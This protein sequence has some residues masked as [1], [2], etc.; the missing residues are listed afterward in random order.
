[1]TGCRKNHYEIANGLFQKFL[2]PLMIKET[3]FSYSYYAFLST[4]RAKDNPYIS[5]KLIFINITQRTCMPLYKDKQTQ[6]QLCHYYCFAKCFIKS[7]FISPICFAENFVFYG[8]LFLTKP[9]LFALLI[10]QY[11]TP[12]PTYLG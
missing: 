1:M 10:N 12:K 4:F 2:I 3:K 11:P 6:S 9:V 5:L 7:R 8:V